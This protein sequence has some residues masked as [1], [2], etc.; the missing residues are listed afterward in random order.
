MY[1]MGYRDDAGDFFVLPNRFEAELCRAGGFDMQQVIQVRRDDLPA[2]KLSTTKAPPKPTPKKKPAKAT[3]PKQP[4]TSPSAIRLDNLNASLNAFEVWRAFK[5]LVIGV[6]K[7]V[8]QHVAK[9]QLSCSKRV[10]QRLL[11]QHTQ[12]ERYQR[13]LK[14]P[15]I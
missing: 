2:A 8:F 10:V 12:D 14:R 11:R 4:T 13:N 3:A 6:E 5:P 1:R 7:Q 15:G 9:H